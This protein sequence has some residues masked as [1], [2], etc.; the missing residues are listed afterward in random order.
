[1]EPNRGFSCAGGE[2]FETKNP[3]ETQVRRNE[4]MAPFSAMNGHSSVDIWERTSS[5]ARHFVVSTGGGRLW[6]RAC[7]FV[8][9][10]RY[11]RPDEAISI[12]G[13]WI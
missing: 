5:S 11:L 13:R 10:E 4:T 8:P 2:N 9:C 7:V 6:K 1:M 3:G 12:W